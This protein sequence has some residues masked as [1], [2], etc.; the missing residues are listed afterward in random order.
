MRSQVPGLWLGALA[1]A[2]VAAACGVPT[3]AEPRPL[4]EDEAPPGLFG[5]PTT[6][7]VPVTSDEA[8]AEATIYLVGPEERLVPVARRV[9]MTATLDDVLAALTAGPTEAE[10]AVS[11]LRT[12]IPAGATAASD[13]VEAEVAQVDLGGAFAEAEGQD[14][15]GAIAQVVFTLTAVPGIEMVRFELEGRPIEVPADDGVL[16][17]AP[18][19]RREFPALAPA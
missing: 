7:A 18:L 19:G 3:D 5:P 2:V 17:G 14:L 1:A 15:V 13:G 16:N 8:T 11:G 12:T 9:P 4:L 6:T 10:V